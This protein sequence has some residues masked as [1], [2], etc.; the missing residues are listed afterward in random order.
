[1]KGRKKEINEERKKSR[2]KEM[3]DEKIERTKERK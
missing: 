3:R 1:M 2:K